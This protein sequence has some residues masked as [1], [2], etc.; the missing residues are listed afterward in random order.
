MSMARKA[1]HGHKV[2]IVHATLAATFCV[3]K[4]I[5]SIFPHLLKELEH[6]AEGSSPKNWSI[7]V[8]ISD[9]HPQKHPKFEAWGVR[10]V[11]TDR[12]L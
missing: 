5:I 7:E 8:I 1:H 4:L 9:Q 6:C 2:G 11:E 3:L 10:F 12:A